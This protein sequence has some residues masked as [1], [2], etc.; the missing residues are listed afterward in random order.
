V[1]PND[2]E[3]PT[4]FQQFYEKMSYIL[5]IGNCLYEQSFKPNCVFWD[6][7]T[8]IPVNHPL[9]SNYTDNEVLIKYK[10]N[11]HD[12][13]NLQ[14]KFRLVIAYYSQKNWARI[15]NANLLLKIGDNTTLCAHQLNGCFLITPKNGREIPQ[16]SDDQ[17]LQSIDWSLVQDDPETNKKYITAICNKNHNPLKYL[18]FVTSYMS[19]KGLKYAYCSR[20]V[21][22]DSLI[23]ILLTQLPQLDMIGQ[24]YNHQISPGSSHVINEIL[25]HWSVEDT[26]SQDYPYYYHIEDQKCVICYPIPQ[27]WD[28]ITNLH[29][30]GS[31]DVMKQ[32]EFSIVN[33][34]VTLESALPSMDI[35]GEVLMLQNNHHLIV[36]CRQHDLII[37]LPH[38]TQYLPSFRLMFDGYYWTQRPFKAQEDIMTI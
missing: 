32:A 25:L 7:E 13:L 36:G 12:I 20:H 3:D 6:Q 15:S 16:I 28:S 5:K 27:N 29:I 37:Q 26:V 9:F 21:R 38:T 19:Q 17:E 23:P 30:I 31:I 22:Y 8:I 2:E 11:P 10:G 14:L 4:G 18:P 1:G 34:N 24:Q 35:H 33:K